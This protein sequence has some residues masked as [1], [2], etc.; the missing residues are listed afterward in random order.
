MAAI[1]PSR[2]MMKSVPAYAG[3]P[4]AARYPRNPPA[5]AHF[6][7]LDNWLI[8]KVGM[9]RLDSAGDA[10]DLVAATV[11]ALVGIVEDDIFGVELVDRC[12]S[13]LRSFS[14][15]T[16]RRF[17]ISKVEMPFDIIVSSFETIWAIRGLRRT[18]NSLYEINTFLAN[19]ILATVNDNCL[20]SNK[21]RIIT[22][23]KENCAGDIPRFS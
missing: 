18:R 12:A 8:A 3:I 14:P 1:R 2:A 17:R 7:G 22:R 4:R 23:Q 6:F 13:P 20:S 21:R 15:K 9:G 11:R 19:A 16:S 10:I 5:I